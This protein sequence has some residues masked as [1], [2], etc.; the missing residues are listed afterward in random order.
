M[1]T[2]IF[3]FT[4]FSLFILN[5]SLAQKPASSQKLDSLL[6]VLNQ[7]NKAMV[8]VSISR[9]GALE[10]SNATGFIDNTGASPI[11]SNTETC[12]RIGS[13]SK[14]F[15]TVMILQLVEEGKITTDTRLSAFYKKVPNADKITIGDLL[16]HHS[17]LYN[18]TNSD[19]Y[20]TWMT[21]PRS[22][23]QLLQLIES[24]N[25][26]FEPREKAEYSNT[27]FVLLGFIIEDVTGKTY[28][29]NL[30]E[31][32]TSRIGLKN[33]MYGNKI[34]HSA[35]E[36]SSFE[37]SNE[38]WK[39]LPETDMSIPHG[40][41]A[42]ISTT[43]DLTTFITALFNGKL[44]NDNSVKTMTTITDGYGS[45]LFKIPFYEKSAFGHNGG[46]DGFS[47]S[48]AYFPDEKVAIAFCSNGLNF[49]MNDILIGVLSCYYGKPY[50]I[51]DFKSV[52]ISPEKL[53]AY[54]GEYSSEQLPLL[55]TV[56]VADGKLTA[57]ATGQGAFPLESVSEQEFH[58]DQAG[59]VMLFDIQTDG[60][61]SGF[62]LRQGAEYQYTKVK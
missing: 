62:I 11:L 31:R 48:L 20:T 36:A 14:M 9:N 16:N 21:E 42:L 7:K 3:L 38:K 33:T 6:Q 26:A 51:P 8:S 59:V 34:N 5:T 57:Q 1:K 46:I 23:A 54:E 58:F 18:F 2:G 28:Q 35:N 56:K 52:A 47:S 41:G 61:V 30:S 37:F 55:I 49:P 40:A 4:F 10:Y 25:P 45:G 13:I 53:K 24:Q 60:T 32:I 39:L 12:Y 22:K 15:T 44:L 29:H 27:N 43:P 50:Q 17:G 19:D